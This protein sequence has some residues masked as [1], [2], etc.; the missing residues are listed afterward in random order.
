MHSSRQQS[1]QQEIHLGRRGAWLG[2]S[3]I[4]RLLGLYGCF[5]VVSRL[6][7]FRHAK[8]SARLIGL[9]VFGSRNQANDHGLRT[10]QRTAYPT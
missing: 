9:S 4:L 8:N 2:T 10:V 3:T 5:T 7:T 6:S 1:G